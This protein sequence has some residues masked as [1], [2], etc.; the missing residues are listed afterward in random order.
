[1]HGSPGA[2][3]A[4]RSSFLAVPGLRFGYARALAG[5]FVL[6]CLGVLAT[7]L[8]EAQPNAS[9][10]HYIPVPAVPAGPWPEGT[11]LE[12]KLRLVD[13]NTDLLTTAPPGGLTVNVTVSDTTRGGDFLA[14]AT[15]GA[16][17]VTFKE[18]ESEATLSVPTV[19]DNQDEPGG[20]ITMTIVA[21][22]GY[23]L[24]VLQR[25]AFTSVVDNDAVA[26]LRLWVEDSD[27]T[28]GTSSSPL[29]IAESGGRQAL[30]ATVWLLGED[31]KPVRPASDTEV[32]LAFAG[33]DLEQDDISAEEDTV[34]IPAGRSWAEKV[35]HVTPNHDTE[36]EAPERFDLVVQM[37]GSSFSDRVSLYLVDDGWEEPIATIAAGTSPVAEGT[38]A[39][40][41]VT[42]SR[43]VST[44][45]SVYFNIW[46][47]REGSFS[48]PNRTF[49]DAPR[50]V[51]I[52]AN[53]T[54]GTI[55]I[56]THDDAV[57]EPDGY[58]KVIIGNI[59]RHY[60]LPGKPT[61]ANE[62]T[63]IV[64][65]NDPE[66]APPGEGPGGE[67][68]AVL[69]GLTVSSV[70]GEPTQLAVAWDAVEGAAK[71]SVRWKTGSGDYGDAVEASTNRHTVTGLSAG[72][73][74]TVNVAAI[75]G[76]N[77][78]LAEGVASG[79]TA[80]RTGNST[81]QSDDV[82]F[83]IY[84]D[85]DAGDAAVHRYEQAIALLKASERSYAV[86]T[87]TGTG[88]VDRLAG[89]T[90]SIMPR[91]FLGDPTAPGW[92]PS[93]PRVNNGGL[94]WLRSVVGSSQA[95]SAP[96]ATRS[97][98]NAVPVPALPVVGQLV[99]AALMAI[100]GYRRYRRR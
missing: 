53:A 91:F 33:I 61:T 50:Y 5:A 51:D 76:A 92:G 46:W 56:P 4:S 52:A 63:V 36:Q 69:T 19:D 96:E 34:T 68:A 90:D 12:F 13:V 80:A 48:D 81:G 1:M 55:T 79:T 72:T 11:V 98:D 70:A 17:T 20:L 26:G 95:S 6:L 18:G 27:L 38:D 100:G 93:Q 58:V 47:S 73:T 15:E 59:G 2:R 62:A 29:D 65:D 64:T 94:R 25:A 87:V 43:A 42:L 57:D 45:I 82:S 99:L 83:V 35:L 37:E 74:Y 77:T 97:I 24:G 21:G 22:N 40:F 16:K 84:H 41:T 10:A 23:R 85:P 9:T 14:P 39:T 86:R 3:H 78:L 49:V 66:N 28:V 54:T 32:V 89:V 7:P 75:D 8:A 71:Y 30:T 31:G 88:E 67:G 44:P 60:R